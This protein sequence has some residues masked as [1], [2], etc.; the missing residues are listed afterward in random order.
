M[1]I[2]ATK[3]ELMH[4][5]L[6]AKNESLLSKLK[7]VFEEESNTFYTSDLSNLQSRT[8]ASLEAIDNGETRPITE[9]K[10]EIENWKSKQA[11]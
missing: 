7:H 9:F 6:Q 10:S 1:N 8:E 4:L 5:L 2:E 11:I 3:L